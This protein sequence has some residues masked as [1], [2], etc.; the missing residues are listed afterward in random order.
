VD[1]IIKGVKLIV[2]LVIVGV[3]A[4]IFWEPVFGLRNAFVHWVSNDTQ[5]TAEP[6]ARL[7]EKIRSETEAEREYSRSIAEEKGWPQ[8]WIRAHNSPTYVPKGL[9]TPSRSVGGVS[10]LDGE[11]VPM[12]LPKGEVHYWDATR[13]VFVD[14][15]R[16]AK[17]PYDPVPLVPCAQ[18]METGTKYVNGWVLLEDIAVPKGKL[19]LSP[20]SPTVLMDRKEGDTREIIDR[21][22]VLLKR[23]Q[24]SM[25]LSYISP[26]WEPGEKK[27]WKR[28]WRVRTE[29]ECT[30]VITVNGQRFISAPDKVLDVRGLRQK[31]SLV[32]EVQLGEDAPVPEVPVEFAYYREKVK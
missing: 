8:A 22:T 1:S 29:E 16:Q 25:P 17:N 13:P 20:W 27:E 3:V 7:A 28:Q 30:L 4:Y 6:M 32:M 5:T 2:W 9:L 18:R 26:P 11:F 14:Y 31:G 23:G 21:F 19:P 10:Y 15:S 12:T 24:K